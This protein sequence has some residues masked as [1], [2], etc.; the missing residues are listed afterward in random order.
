M[1]LLFTNQLSL[2][3]H[4]RLIGSALPG[5]SEMSVLPKCIILSGDIHEI[6][7]MSPE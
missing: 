3:T 1:D 6:S 4:F 2:G 7:A 5:L